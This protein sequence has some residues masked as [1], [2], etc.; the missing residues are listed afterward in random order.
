MAILHKNTF[1]NPENISDILGQGFHI[2]SKNPVT[3]NYEEIDKGRV[4]Y[5]IP[6]G[7]STNEGLSIH[8]DH[9][10][11]YSIQ[12]VVIKEDKG[13]KRSKYWINTTSSSGRRCPFRIRNHSKSQV[14]LTD[15]TCLTG[16]IVLENVV[17]NMFNMVL[18]VRPGG[19]VINNGDFREFLYHLRSL[20]YP[21]KNIDFGTRGGINFTPK[22]EVTEK[23]LYQFNKNEEF[24]Y[25]LSNQFPNIPRLNLVCGYDEKTY[26]VLTF[27]LNNPNHSNINLYGYN[28]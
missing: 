23:N 25:I 6:K 1:Y 15:S 11:K 17:I 12:E 16:D 8:M 24:H 3:L 18:G 21:I 10:C 28:K 26:A 20:L 27:D 13:N 22:M 2:H 7:S 14:I 19:K 4:N 9:F 5:F